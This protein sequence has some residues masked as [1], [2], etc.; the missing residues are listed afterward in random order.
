MRYR[1]PVE[2]L[3]IA[4]LAAAIGAWGWSLGRDEFDHKQHEALFSSCDD[5]H[6]VEPSGEMTFPEPTLC[7]GCHDGQLARRVD[8]PGPGPR[9]SFQR[10]N[11]GEIQENGR[12]GDDV[13]CA[14]CHQAAGGSPM[15]VRRAPPS[16]T[17]FFQEDHRALAAGATELC[18]ACHAPAEQLCVGCHLGSETLDK[19]GKDVATYHP[20]NFMAQHSAAAWSR[21]SECSSC[22]NTE[23][24]CQDCHTG[25]GR[26]NEFRTVTGYHNKDPNFTLGHGAAARQGLESCAACHAQQDCLVCH[27]AKSGRNISPHGRDFNAERLRD[28]NP[29]FCLYCHFSGALDPPD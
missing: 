21:E 3:V 5:C 28:K 23:A 22:H 8:W 17:P 16:H 20:A 4:A 18:Q 7:Q 10:F 9:P 2:V 25:L 19:P 27:S 29:Q 26:S 24:F 12:F 13:S 15:D 6:S 14:S 11:H 1:R